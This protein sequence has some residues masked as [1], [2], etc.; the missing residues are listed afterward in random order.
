[1][2]IIQLKT[3]LANIARQNPASLIVLHATAG[4]SAR[5]SVGVLRDKGLGYHYII[6]RD[7]NDAKNFATADGSEPLTYYCVP[8]ERVTFHVGSGIPV[9][10]Q[11]GVTNR[12]INRNSI[13]L[14]LA[15][16]QNR[17][18]PQPYPEKQIAVLHDLIAGIR[19]AMP[20][21]KLLTAH[22]FVQPWSRSDPQALDIDA[23]AA[24]HGLTVW[25]PSAAE[26]AKHKP[27]KP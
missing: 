5:S 12:D 19:N 11:T 2:P 20:T 9:P 4:A 25:R 8:I 22:A 14:S 17:K 21:V 24:A 1:M 16:I 26:I 6:G 7:G 27:S 15:N 13:G 23:I 10:Q 18:N 3:P